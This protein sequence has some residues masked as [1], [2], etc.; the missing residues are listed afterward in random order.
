MNEKIEKV[1]E[2]AAQ[3]KDKVVS[4]AKSAWDWCKEN[5][6]VAITAAFTLAELT[7]YGGKAIMD[8]KAKKDEQRERD[9]F[10]YDPHTGL[11]YWTK[12]PMREWSRKKTDEWHRRISNGESY[13]DV[14][15]DIGE[16]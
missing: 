15:I 1:K 6:E 10:I 4:G 9:C 14:L 7:F 8:S 2:K 5:R 3:V 11:R 12:H 13:Y 16:L